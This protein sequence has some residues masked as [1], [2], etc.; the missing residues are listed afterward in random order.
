MGC[1]GGVVALED[2]RVHVVKSTC[3]NKNHKAIG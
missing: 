3:F 1:L 2:G